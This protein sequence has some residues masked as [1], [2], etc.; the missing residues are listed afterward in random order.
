M[1]AGKRIVTQSVSGSTQTF[2]SYPTVPYGFTE[3]IGEYT[4]VSNRC[5]NIA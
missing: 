3:R 5:T 1:T 4:S 2:P